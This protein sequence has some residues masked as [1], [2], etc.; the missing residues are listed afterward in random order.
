MNQVDLFKLTSEQRKELMESLKALEEDG[1]L[2]GDP[3]VEEIT[4]MIAQLADKNDTTA[5]KVITAVCKAMNINLDVSAE[6]KSVKTDDGNA[7]GTR[8]PNRT[9]VMRKHF[10]AVGRTFP[11]ATTAADLTPLYI[12]EFGQDRFDKEVA[13]L[14]EP[15][16]K[17]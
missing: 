8:A 1:V 9:N 17:K 10:K 12:K 7:K 15:K 6:K 5:Q 11:V 16:T 14:P 3:A 4:S 13:I 2:P